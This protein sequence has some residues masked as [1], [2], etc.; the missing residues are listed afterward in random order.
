MQRLRNSA[1]YTSACYQMHCFALFASATAFHFS[2]NK[3]DT[4]LS[5]SLAPAFNTSYGI[6]SG[7]T[8]TLGCTPNDNGSHTKPRR[9]HNLDHSRKRMLCF[10]ALDTI[11]TCTTDI[12]EVPPAATA[13]PLRSPHLGPEVKLHIWQNISSTTLTPSDR[14]AAL[15]TANSGQFLLISQ[16]DPNKSRC[17]G[18][19]RCAPSDPSRQGA[20]CGCHAAIGGSKRTPLACDKVG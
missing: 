9:Q 7:H 12:D 1:R 18:H 3:I 19:A 6:R 16:K 14:G 10:Q 17:C 13:D 4:Y 20:I 8:L 11:F 15:M 5:A 2:N